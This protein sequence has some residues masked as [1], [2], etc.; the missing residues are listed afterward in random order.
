MEG[1]G[2]EADCIQ[3]IYNLGLVNKQMGVLKEALQVSVLLR[4]LCLEGSLFM[5]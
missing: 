5:F 1:I 3:A 4:K 2:V